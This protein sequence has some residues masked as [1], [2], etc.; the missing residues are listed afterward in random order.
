MRTP[1]HVPQNHLLPTPWKTQQ[2]RN[3][4]LQKGPWLSIDGSDGSVD[5]DLALSPRDTMTGPGPDSLVLLDYV[6][7]QS[8]MVCQTLD[9]SECL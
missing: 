4:I 9:Y 1:C 6:V 5:R 8:V 7:G 2:P 3:Q